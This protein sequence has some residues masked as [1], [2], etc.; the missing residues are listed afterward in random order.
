MVRRT[1]LAFTLV[2]FLALSGHAQEDDDEPPEPLPDEMQ[3]AR[4]LLFR[5]D[6]AAVPSVQLF[7]GEDVTRLAACSCHLA[8]WARVDTK[9]RTAMKSMERRR[10]LHAVF[11]EPLLD[12]LTKPSQ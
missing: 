5:L 11:G 6:V 4:D 2:A 8:E 7:D 9:V 3:D 12:I 10:G 1:L